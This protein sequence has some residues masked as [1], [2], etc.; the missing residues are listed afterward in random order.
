MIRIAASLFILTVITVYLLAGVMARYVTTGTGSDSARVVKFGDLTLTE[1]GNFDGTA[2]KKGMIIPGVDLKKDATVTFEAS[3][4]A[5][6]VFVEVITNYTT[7]DHE[8]YSY[9]GDLKWKMDSTW[10]Y[11][12]EDTYGGKARY[13]YFKILDPNT[14]LTADIIANDGKITVSDDIT[15]KTIASFG[16][17]FISLRAGV[18]QS[19]GFKSVDEAWAAMKV[20]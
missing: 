16:D 12:D 13:I 15:E 7:E 4:V 19:G 8:N 2:V 3:E 1:T 9:N 5:T 10:K 18:I 20:K 11:L 6:V 14:A 17:A